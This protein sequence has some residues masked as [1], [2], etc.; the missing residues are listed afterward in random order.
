VTG[1][2]G[3]SIGVTAPSMPMA[4]KIYDII[5]MYMGRLEFLSVFALIG[6]AGGGIKKL[7]EKSFKRLS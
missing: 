3:L 4:L 2:V 6:Y 7:C 5:A 1:N